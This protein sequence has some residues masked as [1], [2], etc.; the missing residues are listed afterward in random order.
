MG[1]NDNSVGQ[2]WCFCSSCVLN[3]LAR[4]ANGLCPET[5]TMN[6]HYKHR[7]IA[8]K[9]YGGGMYFKG[10]MY[11]KFQDAEEDFT[12]YLPFIVQQQNAGKRLALL[13]LTR[14]PPKWH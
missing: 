1:D 13:V 4:C 12:K 8:K 7:G 14:L 5:L 11:P 6:R 10:N 3:G 9:L 2:V